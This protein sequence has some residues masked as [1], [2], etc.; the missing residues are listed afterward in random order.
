MKPLDSGGP[1]RTALC[2]NSSHKVAVPGDKKMTKWRTAALCVAVGLST[3][4]AHADVVQ[5]VFDVTAH[6][7]ELIQM[8]RDLP[9]LST[10]ERD[11]T[12]APE[13]FQFTVQFDLDNPSIRA[14][15]PGNSN[16]G[17][18]LWGYA[19]YNGG[20]GASTSATPFTEGLLS[21]FPPAES[22]TQPLFTQVVQNQTTPRSIF[23]PT[24]PQ[25]VTADVV[26][27][28][29]AT[30]SS[31]D[32]DVQ[33][34]WNYG[35]GLSLT[36]P[37][38]KVSNSNFHL[39]TGQ[40]FVDALL[41]TVGVVRTDAFHEGMFQSVTEPGASPWTDPYQATKVA[42]TGDVV[43][44]SVTVVPEPSSAVLMGMGL[45]VLMVGLRRKMGAKG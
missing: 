4:A 20:A 11:R 26:F 23:Y 21:G 28:T 30:W 17:E 13:P 10:Y 33:N 3:T 12:F 6:T 41:A 37:T 2:N 43:L 24:A 18:I 42:I 9:E 5:V 16:S 35:R 1:W 40:E 25:V 34:T 15:G 38:S 7:R 19:V 44:R 22:A 45:G 36:L 29:S 39:W 14:V 8:S 31:L 27:G 32:N